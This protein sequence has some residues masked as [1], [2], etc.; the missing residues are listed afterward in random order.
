MNTKYVFSTFCAAMLSM[1][2]LLA[3]ADKA[4]PTD[5]PSS[6]GKTE[7]KPIDMGLVSESF[8]Y[9]IGKNLE[10]LGFEFDLARV[11]K[12]MQDN[13]TGKE[14]PMNETEC[15]QA[16]SKVQEESFQ[17]LAVE[18]LEVANNFMKENKANPDIVELEDGL[19]QYKVEQEGKGDAVQAH[20]SPLVR[21]K[22]TFLDGNVFGESSEDEL[23]SLDE[24][25]EGFSKGIV[26]MKEGEKRTLFI[27]PKLGF[28]DQ[29]GMFNPNSLLTFEIEVVK[30]DAPKDT[31]EALSSVAEDAT[32]PEV[33]ET[34]APAS[35]DVLQ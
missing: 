10:S 16:I 23:I 20:F 26:G 34:D 25:I 19:L 32:Q 28:G 13:A 24:T 22:G 30:A 4:A 35:E 11:V 14:P 6:T 33:A 31:D 2:N 3:T 7:E 1:G 9:L 17:K 18:N 12:G 21:Y 27:H 5:E 8:G 15:V 29:Q